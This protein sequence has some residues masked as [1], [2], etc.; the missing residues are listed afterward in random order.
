MNDPNWPNGRCAKCHKK[1]T[2]A[3]H[4]PCIGHLPG[5]E[6]ACCGHGNEEGYISFVNGLVIRMK[7]FSVENK[8]KPTM[9]KKEQR[10]KNME[11]LARGLE[12]LNLDADELKEMD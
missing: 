10:A 5:V 8:T 12:V 3:G 1:R 9:T 4:D 11:A 6:Y 2:K 7:I